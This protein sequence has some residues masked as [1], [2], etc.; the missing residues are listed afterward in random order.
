MDRIVR[1]P[2]TRKN[3]RLNIENFNRK[4]KHQHFIISI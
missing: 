1:L 2:Y 3:T 4:S